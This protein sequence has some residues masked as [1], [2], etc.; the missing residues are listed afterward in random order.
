MRFIIFISIITVLVSLYIVVLILCITYRKQVNSLLKKKLSERK[1][2]N[3]KLASNKTEVVVKYC[4]NDEEFVLKEILPGLKS[5]KEIK[6]HT[7]PIRSTRN[8][9]FIDNLKM[10]VT[11]AHKH[12]SIVVFSPN[13]LTS[14]YSHV[15]I[16]KIHGE[17]L[18]AENAVY[19]F[20]DVG[21][22]NSI[23]A[24]LKE[25]RDER[26]TVLWGESD[27]WDK[28]LSMLSEEKK[29]DELPLKFKISK[30]KVKLPSN[31]SFSRLPDWSNLNNLNTFTHSHV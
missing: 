21:P 3:S 10:C 26:T 2:K 5:H 29:S 12:T 19:V 20:T 30:A 22:E 27:F 15:N 9:Q 8:N 25:Q 17:M 4:E 23:Y 24:F 6:I 18:K 11:D 7:D 16:K 31:I 14:T 28:F 1:N 13:Y